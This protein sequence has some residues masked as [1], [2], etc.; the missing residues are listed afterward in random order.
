[1]SFKFL[2]RVTDVQ[3]QVSG[4]TWEDF[5]SEALRGTMS[6][7][8]PTPRY[9]V[10]EQK[11]KIVLEAPDTATLLRMFLGEALSLAR[12]NKETFHAVLFQKLTETCVQA[13]L[14]ATP[15]ESFGE[16]IKEIIHHE[17][18]IKRNSKGEWETVF[19]L[20]G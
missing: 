8:R 4:R 2:E 12:T 15:V 14:T 6:A 10:A 16:D 17:T 7:M 1:M 11:R 18:A 20:D 13:L 9:D 5:F 19:G 3:L